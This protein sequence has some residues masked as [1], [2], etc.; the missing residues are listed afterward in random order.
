MS[1][2]REQPAEENLRK[3]IS[4]MSR[5]FVA[6]GC[7]YESLNPD[8][9]IHSIGIAVYSGFLLE[10]ANVV[11][12]VTAGHCLKDELDKNMDR[13]TLRITGGGFMDYFGLEAQHFHRIPYKYE[14]HSIWYVDEPVLGLDFAVKPLNSLECQAFAE[15][16]LVPITRE[17]W[18]KQPNL[19]FKFFKMLGIPK[20][21]VF[22]GKK[23]DD[24][25]VQQTMV[26]VNQISTDEIGEPPHGVA[27]PSTN[28]FVGRID[29]RTPPVDIKGMSGGP[30]YGFRVDSQGRLT[31]HVVALQSRW[32][33]QSRTIFGCSLP[34]FA[35]ALHHLIADLD[36][37]T[38]T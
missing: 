20:D 35:E 34:V 26:A 18:I 27:A 38:S 12:W 23:L 6:L 33:D 15:N 25:R 31:Y 19:D 2:G 10:V 29:E 3:A 14:P 36:D 37:S 30:I 11:C 16:G 17:N 5:H 28:W 9:T 22:Q 32:W 8:G 21:R 4:W 24:V 1:K 13:G 7:E